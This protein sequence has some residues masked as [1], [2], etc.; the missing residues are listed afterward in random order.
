MQTLMIKKKIDASK[1]V[2]FDLPQ[3]QEGEEIELLIVINSVSSKENSC[4]KF[5]DI[6]KWADRWET[7][8]GEQIQSTDVNNFTGRRF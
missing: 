8:L 3:F 4:D 1:K 6:E 5:F 7:N 2:T